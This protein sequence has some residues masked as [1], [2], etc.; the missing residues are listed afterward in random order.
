MWVKYLENDIIKVNRITLNRND[1]QIET[2]KLIIAV[3]KTEKEAVEEFDAIERA[4]IRGDNL[5][6]ITPVKN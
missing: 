4:L 5:Y 2:D 3:F 6:I 1:F